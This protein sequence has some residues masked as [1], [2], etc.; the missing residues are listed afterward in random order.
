MRGGGGERERMLLLMILLFDFF[1]FFYVSE[2]RLSGV[3]Y[4]VSYNEK[5][6]TVGSMR[7]ILPNIVLFACP[8]VLVFRPFTCGRH[9]NFS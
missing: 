8:F 9:L 3:K 5:S 7:I 4:L 1:F 6:Y 2:S